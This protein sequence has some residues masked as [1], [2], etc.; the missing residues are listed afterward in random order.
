MASG[1]CVGLRSTCPSPTSAGLWASLGDCESLLGKERPSPEF[2]L[3]TRNWEILTAAF[4][5]HPA[6]FSSLSE[7]RGVSSPGRK[8][9]AL[10]MGRA[11]ILARPACCPPGTQRGMQ[12]KGRKE[13]TR[14][15]EALSRRRA[16][17]LGDCSL[18]SHSL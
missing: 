10:L 16:F 17:Y 8:E 18:C 13:R 6:C 4:L 11:W 3:I 7:S 5:K 14:I 12:R 9:E 1:D 2:R 15:Q